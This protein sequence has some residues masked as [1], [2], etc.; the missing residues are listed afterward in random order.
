MDMACGKY[1]G[2][3]KHVHGYGSAPGEKTSQNT[4]LNIG[5]YL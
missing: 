3:E 5:I 2:A 1:M 4:Y